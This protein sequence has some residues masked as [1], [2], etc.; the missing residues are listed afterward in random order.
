MEVILTFCMI[1]FRQSVLLDFKSFHIAEQM[2]LLDAELFVQL[3]PTEILIWARE[4]NEELSPNLT[5]F[6]EQFNNLSYW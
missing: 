1:H 4:Q 5:H 3:E 6:T 2:T